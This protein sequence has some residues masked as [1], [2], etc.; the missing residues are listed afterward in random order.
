MDDDV[1]YN[2]NNNNNNNIVIINNNNNNNNNNILSLDMRRL[3]NRK[4]YFVSNVS[5]FFSLN[6]INQPKSVSQE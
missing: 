5:L 6:L 4:G 1:D 3:I 2:N